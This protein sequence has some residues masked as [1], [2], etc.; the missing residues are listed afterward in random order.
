T[1]AQGDGGPS[2]DHPHPGRRWGKALPYSGISREAN[3]ELG[4]KSIRFSL[5]Y[6]EVFET[7]IRAILRAGVDHGHLG[8]LFPLIS[9][10][11]E[12]M[13]ARAIVDQCQRDLSREKI[14]QAPRIRVGMMIELPSVLGTLDELAQMADFFAVGT[15]DLIQYLLG[16]DRSNG[17]VADHYIPHHP[18]VNQAIQEIARAAQGAGIPVSV[19]GEMAHDPDHIPFL[20]GVGIR[21]LSVDPQFLPD[22]RE[23]I[24]ALSIEEARD[25]SRALLEKTRVAETKKLLH[26]RPG[27]RA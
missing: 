27:Q 18:A 7:Q 4:L 19:C 15:N 2:G 14:P 11:D 17:L 26:K 10:V 21:R 8:I 3:P 12:F 9:S 5:R 20:L 24:Q 16:V 23:C 1:I 22:V 13:E 25:Y 6:R